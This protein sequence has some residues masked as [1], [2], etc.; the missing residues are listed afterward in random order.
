MLVEFPLHGAKLQRLAFIAPGV[1]LTL[2]LVRIFHNV[3]GTLRTKDARLVVPSLPVVPAAHLDVD[4]V[5][6]VHWQ[7]PAARRRQGADWMRAQGR[8]SVCITN[9]VLPGADQ[10]ARALDLRA[11]PQPAEK[12]ISRLRR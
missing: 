8:G 5:E 2:A 9:A 7:D 6:L 12:R 10:S 4:D 3:L 1:L 11:W